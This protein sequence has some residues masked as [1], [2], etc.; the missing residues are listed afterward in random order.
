MLTRDKNWAWP[1]FSGAVLSQPTVEL[2]T[3]LVDKYMLIAVEFGC[4]SSEIARRLSLSRFM[5]ARYV[6]A[7]ARPSLICLLGASSLLFVS[8]SLAA[9]LYDVCD[10]LVSFVRCRQRPSGIYDCACLWSNGT[11]HCAV[12]QRRCPV[13]RAGQRHADGK[14]A[15]RRVRVCSA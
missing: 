8:R 10:S 3:C 12:N 9:F 5:T 4:H 1:T 7:G 14:I 15:F 2:P 13:G 11:C 6:I